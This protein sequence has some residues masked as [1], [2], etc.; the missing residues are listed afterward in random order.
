MKQTLPLRKI[1]NDLDR[2]SSKE[3]EGKISANNLDDVPYVPPAQD[4]LPAS[5]GGAAPIYN[6]TNS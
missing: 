5:T 3:S 1:R 2:M 4:L 6:Y